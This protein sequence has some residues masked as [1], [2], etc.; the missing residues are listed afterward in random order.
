M[1]W[2]TAVELERFKALADTG[3]RPRFETGSVV[4]RGFADLGYEEFLILPGERLLSLM[5]G[6]ITVMPEEHRHFFIAVP[7]ESDLN[8]ALD[9]AGYRVLAVQGVSR[10]QWDAIIERES[11]KEQCVCSGQTIRQALISALCEV[12]SRNN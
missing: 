7:S 9:R 10:R 8:E 3:F 12:R 11:S 5:S 6:T 1:L 4:A 2:S